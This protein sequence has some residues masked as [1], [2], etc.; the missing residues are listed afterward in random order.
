METTAARNM[1]SSPNSGQE[2]GQ[3]LA[4]GK[5]RTLRVLRLHFSE[6]IEV[7]EFCRR[8]PKIPGNFPRLYVGSPPVNL[9]IHR[10]HVCPKST[11][12]PYIIGQAPAITLISC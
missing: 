12:S 9:M 10:M 1:W 4:V 5:R 11:S 6:N 7:A 3:R 8:V 2:S